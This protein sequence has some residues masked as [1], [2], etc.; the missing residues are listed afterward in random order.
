MFWAFLYWLPSYLSTVYHLSLKQA[1]AFAIAPWAA[2]VVAALLGSVLVD[3]LY[4]PATGAS[5][6]ASR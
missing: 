1:G 6:A 2:G 5:E 3:R 4:R